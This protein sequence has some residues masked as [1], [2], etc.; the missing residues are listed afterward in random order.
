LSLLSTRL[1]LQ[2]FA[3][4]DL[5][6]CLAARDMAHTRE[7]PYHPITQGKIER[8]PG[9]LLSAE[10]TCLKFPST[11]SAPARQND[12]CAFSI[13]ET[14]VILPQQRKGVAG[15]RLDQRCNQLRL[16]SFDVLSRMGRC[17]LSHTPS[18]SFPT[19]VAFGKTVRIQTIAMVCARPPMALSEI[20]CRATREPS[21]RI[22]TALVRFRGGTIAV[23]LF[24]PATG[25]GFCKAV[26]WCPSDAR[27]KFVGQGR[28]P[29]RQCTTKAGGIM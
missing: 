9:E 2:T 4:L 21:H 28:S 7:R 10:A 3:E 16:L 20:P 22:P 17:Q 13:L 29:C 25:S 14:S 6:E 8:W 11:V 15:C 5:A 1:W 19:T 27:E 12:R 26:C 24:Q 23:E 18:R